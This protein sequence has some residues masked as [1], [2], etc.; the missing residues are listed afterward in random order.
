MSRLSDLLAAFDTLALPAVVIDRRTMSIVGA[1]SVAQKTATDGAFQDWAERIHPDD[2]A[3]ITSLIERGEPGHALVRVAHENVSYKTLQLELR[4]IDETVFITWS[5][6]AGDS[7]EPELDALLAALPFDVWQRDDRGLLVR[8]NETAEKN[9]NAKLGSPIAEMGLSPDMTAM[10]ADLNA[11]VLRGEVVHKP[12]DYPSGDK[13]IS[14]M[15]LL[16]PVRKHGRICGVVGVNIDVTAMKTAE[17]E[18]ARAQKELVHRERL[19]A[20]GELAAVVAHEVRNPLA[21]IFNSLSSL[22]RQLTL[23]GDVAILFGIL[24]EE[25]ERLNRTVGDLLNYVR[26]LEPERRAEDL[27]ELTRD[28]LRQAMSAAP[29]GRPSIDAEISAK[30]E[31]APF[32]GDPVLL[33]VALVNLLVNAVQAM[34]DGGRLIVDLDCAR[35]RDREA[36]SITVRD[37]GRGIPADELSRVFEPFFT[38]R[39]SGT[40][41]GLALVRRIV[42]AHD[43]TVTVASDPPRG[44][45][46]TIVLPR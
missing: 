15:H 3:R 8:Q 4:P 39:A 41:L 32:V 38:T 11:R 45:S 25:A 9:W 46:F 7:G 6:G 10:W 37:T 35:E 26:P 23:S 33:R 14:H 21:S 43:G 42:E 20:L 31:I 24:E 16:A 1:S 17:A 19:A 12:Q 34:P 18:L 13:T 44:A 29:P 5:E 27:V 30:T 40:G 36:V 22:R 2:R 28:A